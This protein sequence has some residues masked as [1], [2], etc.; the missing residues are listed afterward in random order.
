MCGLV[1]DI[2]LHILEYLNLTSL[3]T[4][5]KAFANSRARDFITPICA[6][7]A[8]IILKYLIKEGDAEITV[9]IRGDGKEVFS[10]RLLIFPI[11]FYFGFQKVKVKFVSGSDSSKVTMKLS[12]GRSLRPYDP[13]LNGTE[14]AQIFLA[15]IRYSSK[16]TVGQIDQESISLEY[17]APEKD[18]TS[19]ISDSVPEEPTLLR[20]MDQRLYFCG[21]LALSGKTF[22]TC[23]FLP[24]EWFDILGDSVDISAVFQKYRLDPTPGALCPSMLNTVSVSFDRLSIPMTELTEIETT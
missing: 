1:P 21:V 2:W 5:S 20:R 19:A 22:A 14:S 10:N 6:R 24:R 15:Y 9:G 8:H 12:T 18:S 23:R 7:Q 17:R 3:Y 11:P 4:L 16:H 13:I